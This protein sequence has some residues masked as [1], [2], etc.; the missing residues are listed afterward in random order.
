MKKSRLCLCAILS[1]IAV[2]PLL[3]VKADSPVVTPWI[4]VLGEGTNNWLILSNGSIV[5]PPFEFPNEA[6][7]ADEA[8]GGI[9][10]SGGGS[11]GF[12]QGAGGAILNLVHRGANGGQLLISHRNI[13]LEEQDGGAIVL[14]NDGS[15]G[16]SVIIRYDDHF[17]MDL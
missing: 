12:D 5:I 6:L 11:S 3:T 13:C 1:F 4:K 14:G 9:W 17:G 7:G 10:F 2:A 15:S 8:R 16:G